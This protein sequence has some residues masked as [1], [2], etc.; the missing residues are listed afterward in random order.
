LLSALTWVYVGDLLMRQALADK[1]SPLTMAGSC[2]Q[3][4]PGKRQSRHGGGVS[5]LGNIVTTPMNTS[6]RLLALERIGT[7]PRWFGVIHAG[8]G[9][10][11]NAVALHLC[12]RCTVG[13]ERRVCG[14][15]GA[16][17]RGAAGGLHLGLRG[18]AAGGAQAARNACVAR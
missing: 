10:P 8:S 15:G 14:A 3:A 5:I 7:P 12:R 16:V 6:R 4:V 2:W 13:A 17:G 18:G 11:R 9:M 1:A